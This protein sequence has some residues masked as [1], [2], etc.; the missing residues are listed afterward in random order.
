MITT[1]DFKR[2]TK[3][4]FKGEPYEVIEFQHVKMQQRAPIVRTKLKSLKTGRVLEETFPAGEKFETPQ[5]EEKE[6]QYLYAQDNLH[7]FMDM[8]TYEQVGLTEQQLGDSKKFIKE[9]MIVNI[10]Y[11]KGSPLIVNPPMFVE[12]YVKET[13]PSFKG[14]TAS[15]GSKPAILET[16]AQVKVPFHI[17]IGDLLKIDTRTGEYIEKVGSKR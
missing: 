5:L 10:L 1:G 3:I 12:L 6:M 16:G 11:Y 4:E 15:A 17:Q 7:Y 8:E 9:E 14:D 2:G 13:E